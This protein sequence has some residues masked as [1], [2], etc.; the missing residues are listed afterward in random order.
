VNEAGHIT[1]AMH[2]TSYSLRL[3]LAGD[4]GRYAIIIES[5]KTEGIK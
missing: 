4:R 3:S 2:L 5:I 1:I